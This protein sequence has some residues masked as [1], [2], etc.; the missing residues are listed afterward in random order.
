MKKSYRRSETALNYQWIMGQ[1]RPKGQERLRVY[2]L[3]MA[4][5]LK[6]KTMGQ[7]RLEMGGTKKQS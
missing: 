2:G 1:G 5:E 7:G 6:N 4:Y 3:R